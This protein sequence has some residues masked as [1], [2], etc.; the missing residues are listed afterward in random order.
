MIIVTTAPARRLTMLIA[1]ILGEDG[2]VAGRASSSV[3]TS[4]TRVTL[5]IFLEATSLK[6]LAI[7][8]ASSGARS[9]TE[10][11]TIRVSTGTVTLILSDKALGDKSNF[12]S[13]ITF[14][15][16]SCARMISR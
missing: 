16:T 13:V 5:I 1:R 3:V 14:S 8:L 12:R 2:D 9:L 6:V 11:E 10:I 15:R 7:R 4:E